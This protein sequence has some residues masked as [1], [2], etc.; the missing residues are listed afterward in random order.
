MQFLYPGFLWFAAAIAIPIIIHLF[1][2]RRFKKVYFTNVKYLE[3]LKEETSRRSKLK[4]ILILL[5]R[6]AAVLALVFAFAQP[7][8]TEKKISVQ[9]HALVS[10]FIDNSQSMSAT[11]NEIALLDL[12]KDKA[13]SIINAFTDNDKFQ[14]LTNEFKGKHQR[15]V[16]KEDAIAFID[17]IE[18]TPIVHTLSQVVDRQSQVF[19]NQSGSKNSY[20]ISDFQTNI[21]DLQPERDTSLT[22]NLIPLRS[23]I[24]QNLSIDS[25]WI[26]SPI[27]LINQ[28]NNIIIKIK[29][30]GNQ[31]LEN[32]RLTINENGQ[33]KPIGSINIDANGTTIDT[34]S[35][36]ISKVGVLPAVVSLTD[37]PITFD[38]SYY[39][40]LQVPDSIKI[41]QI[42]DREN[43]KDYIDA[44]FKD[45]P[46]FS[47]D[48]QSIQQLKYQTFK[49][50]QLILLDD[51]GNVSS[52]LISELKIFVENGGKLVIFPSLDINIKSYQDLA[53]ALQ[54][55]PFIKLE[56]EAQEVGK[57]NTNE[58][59][60]SNVY[61][62][63]GDNLK[64]PKVRSYYSIQNYQQIPTSN[65]LQFRN[66]AP[67]LVKN[68][69]KKGQVFTCA[70]PLNKNSNDLVLN[71]EVFVPMLYKMAISTQTHR[72]L[73][74]TI[75]NHVVVQS[76]KSAPAG[77]KIFEIQ[78]P[79]NFIPN[80]SQGYNSL[81]LN[82]GDQVTKAGFYEL[83]SDQKEIDK[84]ALNY[85]RRESDTK[86]LSNAELEDISTANKNVILFSDEM[87]ANLGD[88]VSQKE[89]GFAWWKY[90]LMAALI[91]LLIE[92]LLIRN[93][94]NS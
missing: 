5:M 82:L 10:V 26:D 69:V 34:A 22:I 84:F 51:V 4:N 59:V 45:H 55:N 6:I 32:V 1:Y 86:L 60:F 9:D 19:L 68:I 62:K 91:F 56:K 66:G 81:L 64:L 80:I 73:S 58:F 77:D 83:L 49:D 71:A 57:I 18:I 41:L 30:L 93:Q 88:S 76:D 40:A 79:T 39:I 54:I 36:Q 61:L 3:E 21:S 23:E 8:F 85:D 33:I 47:V 89:L 63:M 70:S 16:S 31:D 7:F 53:T 87:Q 44:V 78:G 43:S 50:Y 72:P 35:I 27:P 90:A 42:Y 75:S 12:A 94:K 17:E 46:Q 13:R 14:I 24:Q 38:D 92:S 37:Y 28:A 11:S 52:G 48:H 15:L 29:N 25:I 65:L 67:F 20:L 74:Y 2:F